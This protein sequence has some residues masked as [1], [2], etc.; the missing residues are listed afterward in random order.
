MKSILKQV[1][2]VLTLSIVF[3]GISFAQQR[4]KAPFVISANS[5]TKDIRLHGK[6]TAINDTALVIVDKKD[7][8]HYL[9]INKIS[10][11]RIDKNRSEVG[12]GILTGA[13]VA[14]TIV[15]ASGIDDPA[16]AILVGAGGTVVVVTL[17]TII[18]GISHP[19][20]LKIREKDNA[21]NKAALVQKL[22]QYIA[23]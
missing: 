16:T 4:I 14:G 2:L 5:K 12:F 23:K 10:F 11:I 19:A 22:S 21:F 13:A 15:I 8:V 20:V 1:A 7:S 18:H 3:T 9:P 17:M 6:L